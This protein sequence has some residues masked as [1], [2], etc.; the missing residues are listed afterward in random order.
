MNHD[1]DF[2]LRFHDDELPSKEA[3]LAFLCKKENVEVLR[4]STLSLSTQLEIAHHLIE[5]MLAIPLAS[6]PDLLKEAGCM[7]CISAANVPQFSNFSSALFYLPKRL[8]ETKCSMS[9]VEIGYALHQDCASEL[10]ARKYGE[11][12]AKLAVACGLAIPAQKD[13][14]AGVQISLLGSAYCD[15]DTEMQIEILARLCYRIPIIQRAVISDDKKASIEE[16][17]S[18]LSTSVQKRRRHNVYELLAYALNE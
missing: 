4:E 17:L 12:H 10:A 16:S 3:V 8:N 14:C 15:Y 2:W 1:V 11:N 7:E 9:N 6:L 18:V 13:G 5:S